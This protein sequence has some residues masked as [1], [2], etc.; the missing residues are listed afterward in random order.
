MLRLAE[1]GPFHERS[2]FVRTGVAAQPERLNFRYNVMFSSASHLFSG[3]TVL[4]FGSHNG[5]WAHICL[6]LGASKVIGIE[7]EQKWVELAREY[8]AGR[9]CEFHVGDCE[10]FDMKFDNR[11]NIV[12]CMGVL[13]YLKDPIG[14]LERIAALSP[15]LCIVDTFLSWGNVPN[16]KCFE[17]YLRSLFRLKLLANYDGDQRSAYHCFP[18]V[19]AQ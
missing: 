3:K 9:P 10:Q 17:N 14:L 16:R 18:R 6:Q 15:S 5:R 13:Y 11:P 12:L 4:E 2:V 1:Y 19:I 7:L 8:L